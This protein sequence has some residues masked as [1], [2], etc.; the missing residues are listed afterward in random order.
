[1]L[2]SRIYRGFLSSVEQKLIK[3]LL[4]YVPTGLNPDHFSLLALIGALLC[5]LSLFGVWW[6]AF[7]L[8][9]AALGLFLHWLGDSLDGALARYRSIERPKAGFLIDRGGDVLTFFILC[10]GLGVSPFLSLFATLCLFVVILLTMVNSLLLNIVHSSQVLGFYGLGGTEGRL[11]GFIWVGVVHFGGFGRTQF[12]LTTTTL[13]DTI[14][15]GGLLV[16]LVLL[17]STLMHQ[18][19]EYS[20]QETSSFKPGDTQHSSSQASAVNQSLPVKPTLVIKSE[21]IKTIQPRTVLRSTP[22]TARNRRHV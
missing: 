10:A 9:S 4:P 13:W 7:F 20:K 21:T 3:R 8:V 5:A 12:A 6:S 15:C 14:A 16:M 19:N 11:L 17:G 22:Y 2:K 18:I 1:V